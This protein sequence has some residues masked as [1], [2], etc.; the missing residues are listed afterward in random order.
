MSTSIRVIGAART[1]VNVCV[2][3]D[4]ETLADN[5]DLATADRC[6]DGKRKLDGADVRDAALEER[7]GRSTPDGGRVDGERLDV[8]SSAGVDHSLRGRVVRETVVCG[9][10][11]GVGV[12]RDLARGSSAV[13]AEVCP[14]TGTGGVDVDGSL[15]GGLEALLRAGEESGGG[16]QV[17]DV[18]DLEDDVELGGLLGQEVGVLE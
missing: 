9:D 3:P 8:A 14:D 17:E 12:L 16:G 5:T 6:L 11:V 4:V 15:A 10:E 7:S 2:V 13:R 1:V 18:G